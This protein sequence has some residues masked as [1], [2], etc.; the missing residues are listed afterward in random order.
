MASGYRRL[1]LPYL[2]GENVL[3]IGDVLLAARATMIGQNDNGNG[4]GKRFEVQASSEPATSEPTVDNVEQP[5][6]WRGDPW[7][8]QPNE[9][10][11]AFEAFVIYRDLG[12]ERSHAKVA[13]QLGKNVALISRWSSRWKWVER[14]DLWD[15]EQDRIH[16]IALNKER[17]NAARRHANQFKALQTA[18]LRFME[19]KFGKSFDKVD[20]E[21]MTVDQLIRIFDIASKG[22]R[23]S[24][25]EPETITEHHLSGGT[26]SNDERQPIPLTFD[27]RI[28][29]ALGLLEA[30]R[31]REASE[32]S[33]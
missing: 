25:G 30:A 12:E 9:S 15:A 11:K 4:H 13:R 6:R 20:A 8:K 16:R 29:E 19:A 3:I 28:E 24:L 31:E 18:A 2:L 5:T 33:R 23:L 32:T 1:T 26:D 7:E 21:S 22:E 14:V 17:R 27:G 10:A